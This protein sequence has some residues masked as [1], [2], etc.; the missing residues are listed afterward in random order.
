MLKPL[1]MY[2]DLKVSYLK[3]TGK[4]PINT[5][6]EQYLLAKFLM[7]CFTFTSFTL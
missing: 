3:L 6:I 7:D 4:I 1:S 2:A 5:K